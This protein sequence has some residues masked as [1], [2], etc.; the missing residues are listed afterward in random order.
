MIAIFCLWHDVE[1]PSTE[2]K[3][4]KE[5]AEREGWGMNECVA[6]WA[7]F[8]LNLSHVSRTLIINQ[9]EAFWGERSIV[10]SVCGQSS[11]F[12][13]LTVLVNMYLRYVMWFVWKWS[14]PHLECAA[15][16]RSHI[17]F[18]F[19]HQYL[20]WCKCKCMRSKSIMIESV[21]ASSWKLTKLFA[22]IRKK[23]KASAQMRHV[24]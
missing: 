6:T 9:F 18:M 3:S 23:T 4:G 12:S 14:G 20:V 5:K 24:K 17:C 1:W 8:P 11:G 15:N 21:I 22:E 7:S 2:T 10:A 16:G 13:I 19:I